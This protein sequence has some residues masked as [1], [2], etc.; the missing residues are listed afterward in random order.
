MSKELDSTK[1]I[2]NTYRSLEEILMHDY[3]EELYLKGLIKNFEYEP[4]KLVVQEAV[5]LQPTKRKLVNEINYTYD[6]RIEWNIDH[7]ELLLKKFLILAC[8]DE[9]STITLPNN[10]EY[11]DEF[12]KSKELVKLPFIAFYK[13]EKLYSYIDVKG[14]YVAQDNTSALTFPL[15]RVMLLNKHNIYVSK[16]VINGIEKD[17]LF[18]QTFAPASYFLTEKKKQLKIKRVNGK[19]MP[20]TDI[21]K[22]LSAYLSTDIIK[23]NK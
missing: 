13:D 6:F 23:Q 20:I 4:E 2:I 1:P 22:S 21:L 19:L 14:G 15:K 18:M 3:L 5:Y 17:S 10:K 9:N 11:L 16:I 12:N 8:L 7:L